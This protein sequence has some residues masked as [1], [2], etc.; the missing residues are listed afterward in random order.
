MASQN[1][2]KED[3]RDVNEWLGSL[4]RLV[5][6]QTTPF[7]LETGKAVCTSQ[8][9]NFILLKKNN[10]SPF[11]FLTQPAPSSSH[12]FSFPPTTSHHLSAT[13]ARPPSKQSRWVR[14]N[15]PQ[16]Q[17]LSESSSCFCTPE[18]FQLLA[19]LHWLV[20]KKKKTTQCYFEVTWRSWHTKEGWISLG[21]LVH[22][23]ENHFIQ[24]P[25]D[26]LFGAQGHP[27]F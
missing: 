1:I 4:V 15:T 14:W 11:F 24:A 19:P 2:K 23:P 18:L 12:L 13:I 8:A 22:G 16:H 26:P 9:W 20:R 3:K 10:K 21:A 17:H 5:R 27:S 6:S 7:G 25:S